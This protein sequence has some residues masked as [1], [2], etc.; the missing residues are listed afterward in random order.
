MALLLYQNTISKAI[1]S[2]EKGLAFTIASMPA[3][4]AAAFGPELAMSAGL[5]VQ[6]PRQ[7]LGNSSNGW[8]FDDAPVTVIVLGLDVL[9]QVDRVALLRR[10]NQL[11]YLGQ[12]VYCG[13]LVV[14]LERGGGALLGGAGGE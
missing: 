3:L 7:L 6:H 13:D 12:Q 11:E 2:T 10:L 14:Q 9:H 8:I 4:I 5:T 1:V